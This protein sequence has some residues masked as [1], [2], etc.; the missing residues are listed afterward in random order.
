MIN[1]ACFIDGTNHTSQIIP[2]CRG[3]S[4]MM[5]FF[6]FIC[7]G[8]FGSL[9]SLVRNGYRMFVMMLEVS[10]YWPR[11]GRRGPMFYGKVF[12][13]I[14]L[15]F[16]FHDRFCYFFFFELTRYFRFEFMF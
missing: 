10:S 9:I 16:N 2:M 4:V 12:F 1:F 13:V 6:N 8:C 3:L 15:P 5:G 14:M 7:W 11:C